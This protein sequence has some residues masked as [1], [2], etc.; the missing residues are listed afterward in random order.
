MSGSVVTRQSFERTGR[1]VRRARIQKMA[2]VS[3]R[4]HEGSLCKVQTVLPR[5]QRLR[6][7]IKRCAELPKFLADCQLRR[8]LKGGNCT[9]VPGI[10]PEN[11]FVSRTSY[12]QISTG[13]T[14][15]RR[16]FP[17]EIFIGPITAAARNRSAS[18]TCST[19]RSKRGFL[20]YRAV[21]E[22]SGPAGICETHT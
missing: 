1:R 17:K 3:C 21:S 2:H 22:G 6:Q 15:L 11:P 20:L 16:V 9:G 5:N 4:F 10:A 14:V 18:L 8:E 13:I 19:N 7:V 12:R